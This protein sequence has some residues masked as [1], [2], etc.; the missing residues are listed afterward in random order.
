M[1]TRL[2]WCM[3]ALFHSVVGACS[4]GPAV[5]REQEWVE[6]TGVTQKL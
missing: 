5:K 3:H 4:Y 1:P 2:V 6:S